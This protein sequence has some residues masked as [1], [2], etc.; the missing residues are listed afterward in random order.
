[1]VFRLVYLFMV[2]LFGWGVLLAASGASKDVE[3]LTLHHEVAVLRRQVTGPKPDWA[4]RA[5]IAAMS[6]LLTLQPGEFSPAGQT[7]EQPGHQEGKTC[8]KQ[9]DHPLFQVCRH[10]RC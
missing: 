10:A 5:V 2:R 9:P 6:R 8:P 7:F 1:V 3:T 4:D